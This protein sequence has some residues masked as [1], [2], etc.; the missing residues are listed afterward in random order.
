MPCE[1]GESASLSASCWKSSLDGLSS[2]A[3]TFI[4]VLH[5]YKSPSW[6]PFIFCSNDVFGLQ[7]P[8]TIRVLFVVL[9]RGERSFIQ[10]DYCQPRSH[11]PD[12]LA[13]VVPCKCHSVQPEQRTGYSPL[14]SSAL[15][16]SD[17]STLVL[18]CVNVKSGSADGTRREFMIIGMDR[19]YTICSTGTQVSVAKFLGER[20]K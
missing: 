8:I 16:V 20:S 14:P 11:N 10:E 6:A 7:S 17:L 15:G 3:A 1:A 9:L 5:I 13:S 2:H 12:S 19:T 4:V 18:A